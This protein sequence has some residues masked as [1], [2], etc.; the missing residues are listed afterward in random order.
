METATKTTSHYVVFCYTGI[1]TD[2][3]N[4]KMHDAD[5]LQDALKYRDIHGLADAEVWA[6]FTDGSSEQVA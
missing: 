3:L 6:V 1:G 4:L 2:A 5:T